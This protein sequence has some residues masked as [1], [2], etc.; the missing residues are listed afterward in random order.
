MKLM[1][2]NINEI[3]ANMGGTNILDPINA[4]INLKTKN[5]TEKR[6]FLLTDGQVNN[7]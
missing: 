4:S 3:Q 5:V 1:K 2:A 7:S 6:I